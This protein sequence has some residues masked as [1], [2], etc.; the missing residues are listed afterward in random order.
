MEGI[1]EGGLQKFK[2]IT[3]IREGGKY[4]GYNM[5]CRR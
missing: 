1:R 5:D 4:L 3:G 2:Y